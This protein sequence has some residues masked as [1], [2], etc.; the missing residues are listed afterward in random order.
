MI[1]FGKFEGSWCFKAEGDVN[2]RIFPIP[3]AAMAVN[4]ALKQHPGNQC[5]VNLKLSHIGY[6]L[7]GRANTGYLFLLIADS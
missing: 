1:R 3:T 2:H 7:S 5:Y 6:Q 4:S